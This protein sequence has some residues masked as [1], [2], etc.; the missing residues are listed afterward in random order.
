[1]KQCLS[2]I[3][4]LHK[5]TYMKLQH[6]TTQIYK[7]CCVPHKL[8]MPIQDYTDRQHYSKCM[9]K[10]YKTG[11]I[12]ST[13]L[14]RYG[15]AYLNSIKIYIHEASCIDL[16]GPAGSKQLTAGQVWLSACTVPMSRY[17]LVIMRSFLI[18]VRSWSRY[19]KIISC[20][21]KIVTHSYKKTMI[22]E[23]TR[24][25]LRTQ[26]TFLVFSSWNYFVRSIVLHKHLHVFKKIIGNKVPRHEILAS[27]F[28]VLFEVVDNSPRI[29]Q[30]LEA[31]SFL[32]WVLCICR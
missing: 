26:C 29:I 10:Y 7:K 6:E 32:D 12:L 18:I 21:Y 16:S 28:V 24:F 27:V 23:I 9:C 5:T 13:A 22:Y 1:M 8:H 11:K 31:S 19:C 25:I 30:G 15:T 2:R 14:L 4:V 3:M 20:I 17:F